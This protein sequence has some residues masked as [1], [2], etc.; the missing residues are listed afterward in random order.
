[1][2]FAQN[3]TNPRKLLSLYSFIGEFQPF[4]RQYIT[5]VGHTWDADL[6]LV[7][8]EGDYALLQFSRDSPG[9]R[10]VPCHLH[11]PL[12]SRHVG[13]RFLDSL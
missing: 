7:V 9:F 4:S 2:N 12:A 10:H 5:H 8:I 3:W 11:Q 13:F 6:T 1:M